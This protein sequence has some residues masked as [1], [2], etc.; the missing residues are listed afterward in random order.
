MKYL[1]LILHICTIAIAIVYISSFSVSFCICK[2]DTMRIDSFNYKG[3]KI[4]NVEEYKKLTNTSPFERFKHIVANNEKM[5]L[6]NYT[7]AFSL[8]L[9]PVILTSFNGFIFGSYIGVYSNYMSMDKILKYTLPHSFELIAII[10][11]GGEGLFIGISLI[12]CLLGYKKI[13]DINLK[14][15]AVHFI[16][17][18]VIIILAAF[19]EAYITMSL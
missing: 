12:L 15:I 16:F 9:S 18:T 11:S 10:F 14:K 7:G 3:M 1:T 2:N 4:S 19:V 17:C 8:G 6:L 5:L 13:K